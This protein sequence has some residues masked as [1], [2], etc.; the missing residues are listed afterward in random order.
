[1]NR[2]ILLLAT[3]PAV[4][5]GLVLFGACIVSAWHIN[6][7]QTNLTVILSQNVTS[8]HAA[9]QMEIHLRQLR[10][11]CFLYLMKPEPR[12]LAEIRDLERQFEYWLERAR[13]TSSTTEEWEQVAAIEAGFRH[14]RDEFAAQQRDLDA[15]VRLDPMALYAINPVQHVVAPCQQLFEV[16]EQ[17]I[18]AT[19][20]QSER[21]SRWLQLG[22]L[23]LGI[24]GPLSGLIMG[25]GMARGVSRSLQRSQQLSALGQLAASVAHE[26]RNPLTSIKLLVE[27]ALRPDR[28]R[29]FTADT[30]RVVLGEVV[31]LEKTVHSFLDFARPQP[32]QWQTCDLGELVRQTVELIRGRAR[33]QRV[34]VEFQ[35][36]AEPVPAAVDA[37][38]VRTVLVNL[39]INALDAMPQGGRL[40][41]ALTADDDAVRFTVSDTGP[42][43]AREMTGR[44]FTPF[45]STRPTGTGLGLSISRRIVEEHGG[46][47]AWHNRREGGACFVVTLPTSER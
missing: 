14:Y 42:G 26:V 19:R 20:Q 37:A 32:P 5:I 30:L 7:L 6:R 27:A 13:E 11:R 17:M 44:M 4:I 31:R 39:L 9:Q 3:A 22:L 35:A 43:V 24:G 18:L 36:P 12:V 34:E 46:R 29:P 16:N 47:I 40:D 2:R 8:L 33:Q 1:M 23:F 15:G 25:Y 45:A 21:V 38:Q 28:P 41:V 10:F